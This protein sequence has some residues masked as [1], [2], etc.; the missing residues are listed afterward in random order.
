MKPRLVCQNFDCC[1]FDTGT[2]SEKECNE[3]ENSFPVWSIHDRWHMIQPSYHGC[4]LRGRLVKGAERMV[5]A[6]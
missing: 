3:S 4:G 6:K 5:V 2:Q 1:A